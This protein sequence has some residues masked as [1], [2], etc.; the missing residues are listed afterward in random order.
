MLPFPQIDPVASSFAAGPINFQLT[1]YALA[2]MFGLMGGWFIA[3]RAL[4]RPSLWGGT[5]PM[6]RS[7]FT[8]FV[9]WITAGVVIGG[10]LGHVFFYDPSLL[11]AP[12]EILA[13]WEGG[14][15][16][17]GGLLGVVVAGY[18]FTRRR[19]IPFLPAADAVA[20]VAPIWL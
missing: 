7:A 1:W 11:A 17:H 4:A 9:L 6:S 3:D 15:S 12:L 18:L 2:Y 13:I 16:F 19:A 5:A 10:R 20:C 8:D 14:M